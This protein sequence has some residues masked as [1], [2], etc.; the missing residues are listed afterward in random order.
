[1]KNLFVTFIQ[2]S[3]IDNRY[4]CCPITVFGTAFDKVVFP[5]KI[6]G[7]FTFIF[8]AKVQFYILFSGKFVSL[9]L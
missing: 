3:I 8:R 9:C 5:E 4:V 6:T 2:I 1:M 7:I